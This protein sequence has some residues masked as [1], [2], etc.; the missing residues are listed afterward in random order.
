MLEPERYLK[1]LGEDRDRNGFAR[2]DVVDPKILDLLAH[3]KRRGAVRAERRIQGVFGPQTP[4]VMAES[5]AQVP[6]P[7][8]DLRSN[9]DRRLPVPLVDAPV[10]LESVRID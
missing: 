10:G 9:A 3:E 7:T 1:R 8:G 4:V 5:R 2:I 6:V